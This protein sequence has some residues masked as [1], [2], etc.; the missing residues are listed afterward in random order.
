V[1]EFSNEEKEIDNF[2]FN[3]ENQLSSACMGFLCT[4]KVGVGRSEK[5]R[6]FPLTV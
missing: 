3:I 4:S 6:P 5:I 1:F 2:P